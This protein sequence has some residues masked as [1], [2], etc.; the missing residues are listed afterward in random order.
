MRP[1]IEFVVT[2][3]AVTLMCISAVALEWK[4]VII[5]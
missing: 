2:V 1:W 4:G 5:W 3:I